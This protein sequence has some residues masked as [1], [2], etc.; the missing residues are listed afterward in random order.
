M[1]TVA[2]FDGYTFSVFKKTIETIL[3][4]SHEATLTI[5]PK[6]G[7]LL[8][9]VGYIFQT[10]KS[11]TQFIF[12]KNNFSY[13][14]WE[15]EEETFA[16]DVQTLSYDLK[17]LNDLKVN[18]NLKEGS[19]YFCARGH[20]VPF[21]K[22]TKSSKNTHYYYDT[23]ERFVECLPN[24]SISSAVFVDLILQLC[25]SGK[26]VSINMN[27]KRVKI[28]SKFDVGSTEIQINFRNSY[29]D[30]TNNKLPSMQIQNEYILRFLKPCTHFAPFVRDCRLHMM[31]DGPLVVVMD[32]RGVCRCYSTV[33]PENENQS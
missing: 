14:E 33:I 16:F 32:C 24:F 15:K 6:K 18:V 9:S 23:D 30:K 3:E 27:K 20:V 28:L 1:V 11:S 2:S 13:F 19:I 5:N 7:I 22:P 8:H 25:C 12:Y 17:S 4:S 31:K 21:K 29:F 26:L 10:P